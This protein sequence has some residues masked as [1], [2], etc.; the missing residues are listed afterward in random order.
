[1]PSAE[2]VTQSA[3]RYTHKSFTYLAHIVIIHFEEQNR[4]CNAKY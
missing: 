3:M 1:M 2:N 4:S